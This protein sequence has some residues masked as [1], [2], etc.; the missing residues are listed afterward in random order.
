MV[1]C[2][3]VSTKMMAAFPMH[4]N[5]YPPLLHRQ[6][7]HPS[8]HCA[9]FK[10]RE[11]TFS[12]PCAASKK[13]TSTLVPRV[14]IIFVKKWKCQNMTNWSEWSTECAAWNSVSSQK[15]SVGLVS[16]ILMDTT[17]HV[18]LPAFIPEVQHYQPIPI[19]YFVS[20]L[21]CDS[22]QKS[23]VP[24][25]RSDGLEIRVVTKCADEIVG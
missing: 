6:A 12:H 5:D 15:N 14:D 10:R 21:T 19:N 8:S 24:E 16:L 25:L 2:K 3:P 1:P 7:S 4:K 20:T 18:F 13:G 23:L 9:C 22:V 17:L 11:M